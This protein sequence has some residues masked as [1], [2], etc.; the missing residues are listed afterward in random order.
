MMEAVYPLQTGKY[1][2]FLKKGT[3]TQKACD[4]GTITADQL[5]SLDNIVQIHR[6][7]LDLKHI[8]IFVKTLKSAFSEVSAYANLWNGDIVARGVDKAVAVKWLKEHFPQIE[9]SVVLETVSMIWEWY[10][11][12]R[13]Q[14]RM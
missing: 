14:F 4:G 2:S 12:T 10:G 1:A 11:P 5:E 6:R 3:S 13:E 8:K 7:N 9:R